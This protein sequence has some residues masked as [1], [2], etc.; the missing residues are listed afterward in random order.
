M[1]R[2]HTWLV[3]IPLASAFLGGCALSHPGEPI[4]AFDKLIPL[5]I[6][7]VAEQHL[8]AAG[9]DPGPVDGVF[10]EQTAEALRQYQRRYGLVVSGMLDQNTREHLHLEKTPGDG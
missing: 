2:R 9:F 7:H 10:T 4:A 8:K 3:L 5:G 6:I 1:K